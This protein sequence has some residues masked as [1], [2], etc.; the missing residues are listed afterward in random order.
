MTATTLAFERG[1]ESGRSLNMLQPQLSLLPAMTP[2]DCGKQLP[3]LLPYLR[4]TRTYRR[5]IRA[6][7]GYVA[8]LGM[9][10][11]LPPDRGKKKSRQIAAP[12]MSLLNAPKL[13]SGAQF[14][15]S[16]VPSDPARG[17]PGDVHPGARVRGDVAHVPEAGVVIVI[18]EV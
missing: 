17:R 1:E 6:K 8:S 15:H 13:L 2:C 14:L 3:P 16:A 7:I 10:L 9:Q 4:R 18:V 5:Q 12:H 11:F